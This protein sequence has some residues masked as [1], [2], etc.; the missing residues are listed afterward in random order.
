LP[1]NRVRLSRSILPTF[2]T[3]ASGAPTRIGIQY[4]LRVK[5]FLPA[6]I[7]F[8]T[9]V[10]INNMTF[11]LR[12]CAVSLLALALSGRAFAQT[13]KPPAQADKPLATVNGVPIKQSTLQFALQGAISQGNADS[14]Q[15][16]DALTKQLIARE[17]FVQEAAKQGLDKDPEVL[18]V[19][20]EAKRNAMI[21]RY[22]RAKVQLKP[23]TDEDVKAHYEKVKATF[24]P[25][26]YKMR[27]ILLPNDQR[28]KDLR[29]QL[30]KGADF[31]D[32]A[33]QW[34]LAPSATRG[35][36]VEW[37]SFRTPAKEGETNGLPLPIALALEKMQKGAITNPIEVQGKWWLVKLDDT[38][39]TKVPTFDDT[40]QSIRN[41]LTQQ[42][43]ERAT[44]ELVNSL[45]KGAKITQ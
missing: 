23:I 4:P 32:L 7:P 41:M 13:E 37:V 43:A 2:T 25:K 36:E 30:V 40:K 1:E 12:I 9:I 5:S 21:Q 6:D 14:P 31:A 33:R 26:E 3:V 17:L 18:A 42:E 16:R 19:T 27:V 22:L 35:G 8:T 24:G 15:L 11:T 34:S 28:A 38:R 39:P 29:V 10:R 20:E 45:A 44:N